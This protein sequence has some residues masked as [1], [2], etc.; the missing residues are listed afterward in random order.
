MRLYVNGKHVDVREVKLFEHN[1]RVVVLVI[2]VLSRQD[3]K[4]IV[5]WLKGYGGGD[6]PHRIGYDFPPFSLTRI[7]IP[8]DEVKALVKTHDSVSFVLKDSAKWE[9]F[10]SEYLPKFSDHFFILLNL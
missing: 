1:Q 9:N 2:K 10:V 8:L 3:A 5:E 4:N 6:G 7:I